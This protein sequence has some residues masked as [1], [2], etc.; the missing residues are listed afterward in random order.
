MESTTEGTFRV[1]CTSTGGRALRMSVTRPGGIISDLTNVKE[2]EHSQRMGNDSFVGTTDIISEKGD[3]GL[4][5]CSASN[6][7]STLTNSVT[8][9]GYYIYVHTDS[10]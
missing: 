9:K 10:V 5:E 8:L 1:Q 3:G 4:Y 2:V 6:N 7:L